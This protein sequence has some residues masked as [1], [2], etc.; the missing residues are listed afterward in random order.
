MTHFLKF[1]VEIRG[2]GIAL[3]ESSLSFTELYRRSKK[4]EF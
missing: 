1:L 2:V 4:R 3:P